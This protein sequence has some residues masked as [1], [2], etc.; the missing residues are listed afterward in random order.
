VFR[1]RGIVFDRQDRTDFV[2]GIEEILVPVGPG[3]VDVEVGVV[4]ER[5][6]EGTGG[7]DMPLRLRETAFQFTAL[8]ACEFG[9]D[10]L[11]ENLVEFFL[12]Q[13]P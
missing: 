9:F 1:S 5:E 6:F 12:G 10:K 4:P 13:F 3:F 7:A 11:F 8:I 2:A